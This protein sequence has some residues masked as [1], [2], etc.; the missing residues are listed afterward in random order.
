LK[1]DAVM[2]ADVLLESAHARETVS[3]RS[4]LSRFIL[5]LGQI[6]HGYWRS[7]RGC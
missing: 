2:P 7:P 1:Y 3:Q 5:A 4:S 6:W